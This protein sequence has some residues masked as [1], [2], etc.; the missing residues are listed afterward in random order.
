MLQ[1]SFFAQKRHL[2]STFARCKHLPR[3]PMF[4]SGRV[5]FTQHSGGAAIPSVPSV[6]SSPLTDVLSRAEYPNSRKYILLSPSPPEFAR[7]MDML[8]SNL[9]QE[10]I[11]QSINCSP[12]LLS[13]FSDRKKIREIAKELA[14][15]PDPHHSLQIF[16][17]AYHLGHTLNASAYESVSFHLSQ[18]QNWSIVLAVVASAKQ[19][20]GHTTLRLLNWRALALME[21][22]RYSLLQQMLK[23]F[24]GAKLSPTRR[25]YHIM[26]SG[27]MRNYDLEG[28]KRCLQDMRGAGFQMDAVTHALVG[29]LYRKFGADPQVRQNALES[30][31]GLHPEA[32]TTVINRLIQSSLD[33]HDLSSTVQFL[34]LFDTENVQSLVSVIAIDCAS[35]RDSP[36]PFDLPTLSAPGLKP[37]SD[38]FATFMNYL[39]RKSSFE[40]AIR[41]GESTT[42]MRIS[43]TPNL[44]TSLIHAY[45]LGGHGNVAIRLISA[46][47]VNSVPETFESLMAGFDREERPSSLSLARIPLTTRMCNA[48][49][50]GILNRQGLASVPTVFAIMHANSICPNSRTSE[51]LLSYLNKVN[52][53]RPRTLF[54]ILRGLSSPTIRPSLKHIHHILAR[55]FRDEKRMFFHSAWNTGLTSRK[56]LRN[57]IRLL[58]IGE[59]FDPTSGI[60]LD[61]YLSYRAAA[62]PIVQ[63]LGARGVKSDTAMIYLRIRRH[64]VLHLDVETAHRVLRTLMARGMHPNEYHFGA[65]VEGYALSGNFNGALEVMRTAERS[66]V[67]P[68]VV[69]Y[70]NIIS[71]HARLHDA[72]SAMRTFKEM[73]GAG[74]VPDVPSI[75][76]VV[77]A[78]YAEGAH[79]VA[80][81][82]LMTLWTYV[83]PFPAT[84]EKVDL[85][86]MLL[87]FRSLSSASPLRIKST[88]PRRKAMYQ[89]LKLILEAYQRYFGSRG[90]SR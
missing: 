82:L 23:E 57:R 42:S 56:P 21:T 75:D 54:R 87:H 74:V 31:A 13:F 64:S 22:Q 78:F 89:Q 90:K 18:S 60:I 17:L 24:E 27:C 73:V 16:N 88:T 43:A 59:P 33:S 6:P 1:R 67:K 48:L 72:Q 50:R 83:Q 2:E 80:R 53:P 69:M 81:N 15:S 10:M 41:L 7:V 77:S 12:S 71:A 20:I 45:F 39:I 44:I 9:S 65:L 36:I 30:L 85:A 61:K 46:L 34:S 49:L 4:N 68:N 29:N 47:S 52:V 70:T 62:R 84:L 63:S 32:R 38:T 35:P 3:N 51:V 86:T 76:A 5:P 14:R 55:I 79:T 58:G 19:H 26:L 11:L 37:N 25:T 40:D 28:A 66:G 8:S